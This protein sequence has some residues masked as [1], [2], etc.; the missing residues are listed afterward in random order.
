MKEMTVPVSADRFKTIVDAYGADPARWP[1][2]E[3][4]SALQF[5]ARDPRA[6]AWLD[7][8]RAL[9]DLL[10]AGHDVANAED[11]QA[12][13]ARVLSNMLVNPATNVVVFPRRHAAPRVRRRVLPWLWTGIGLAACIAGATVGTKVGLSSMD[14]VRA[15]RVLDLA[16]LDMEN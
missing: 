11:D 13:Y 3:R 10:D 6:R 7:E 14:D 15:Q 2:A 8:A 12:R 1:A 16:Q 5:M 9:D 4:D